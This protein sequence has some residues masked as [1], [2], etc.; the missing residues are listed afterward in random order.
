MQ[1]GLGLLV[2]RPPWWGHASTNGN[3]GLGMRRRRAQRTDGG[4]GGTRTTRGW[5]RGAAGSAYSSVD[6]APK[7]PTWTK[8][9][10]NPSTAKPVSLMA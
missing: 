4:G 6:R 7:D 5:A 3:P 2:G 10:P 1:L 8:R 9:L